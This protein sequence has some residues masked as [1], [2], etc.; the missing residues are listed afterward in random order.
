EKFKIKAHAVC[1]LSL[2]EYSALVAAGSTDF[3][4][5][6]QLVRERGRL[7]QEAVPI[8][9]GAVAA[10][11]GLDTA[12]IEQICTETEGTV[13]V[14]N[15]N[16]PGQLVVAGETTAVEAVMG[17]CLQ[18]GAKR[19]IKLPVSAPFHTVMLKNAGEA[20]RPHLEKAGLRKP[21]VPVISNL[22]ADYYGDNNLVDLLVGQVYNPVRFEGCVRKLIGDG[23][24]TFVEVGP[25]ST[26]ASFI[27]RIDK[28]AI[29]HSIENRD[30]VK[31][32]LEVW[33]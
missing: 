21:A 23:F 1:G 11:M 9:N 33:N 14:A 6:V 8:G 28:N 26:L 12:V 24:T 20:L 25:G 10:I 30:G 13:S 31:K 32:L 5:A 18:L 19:A 15:Y 2:G 4:T 3:S 7:M 29:V 16:C 17:R 22:T 27:K